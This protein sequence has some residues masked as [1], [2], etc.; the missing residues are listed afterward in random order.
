MDLEIPKSPVNIGEGID[1]MEGGSTKSQNNGDEGSN[2]PQLEETDSMVTLGSVNISASKPSAVKVPT[3]DGNDPEHYKIWKGFVKLWKE[4]CNVPSNQ[5]AYRVILE[6]IRPGSKASKE[7]LLLSNEV[8]K[9]DNGLDIIF[10]KLDEIFL[11]DRCFQAFQAL[12]NYHDLKRKSSVAVSD[13]ITEWSQKL[14]ELNRQS[15]SWDSARGL[16]LLHSCELPFQERQNIL[17]SVPKPITIEGMKSALR[18]SYSH[19]KSKD[20]SRDSLDQFSFNDNDQNSGKDTGALYAQHRG[21]YKDTRGRSNNKY[22]PYSRLNAAGKNMKWNRKGSDGE[23]L[24]C[25]ECDSRK[26]FRHQCP[27]ILYS[28][29]E[30][31]TLLVSKDA[32]TSKD[33]DTT[34]VQIV[35]N[36][37]NDFGLDEFIM[38]GN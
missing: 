27:E 11:P 29:K 35:S 9:K 3:F 37:D 19:L 34:G 23:Y 13:H 24:R 30:K 21:A 32:V 38:G 17:N 25:Y 22:N 26:Y 28:N 36:L 20:D 15:C 5:R 2:L 8:F 16:E 18:M 7:L 33:S 1:P 31:D 4:I 6:G 10:E 12:Q 14:T